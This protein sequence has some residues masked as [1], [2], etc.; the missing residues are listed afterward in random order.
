MRILQLAT[1]SQGGAGIAANRLH[2]ALVEVGI[3]STFYTLDKSAEA[4][5]EVAEFMLPRTRFRRYCSS[6]LTLFQRLLVQKDDK[7][8]TS[9]S[10]TE[11]KKLRKITKNFEVI[12][13]HATYNLV[14]ISKVNLL[15][16]RSQHLYLHLHDQR[17]FTGGCHYSSNC[18]KFK[19]DCG[20]CPQVRLI[21]RNLPK[22][23]LEQNQKT[24]QSLS[25]NLTV[26]SPSLW[27]AELAKESK[28]FSNIRVIQ[29]RNPIPSKYFRKSL[30]N[31]LNIITISFAASNLD[32]PYKGFKVFLK[33]LEMLPPTFFH[34]KNIHIVGKGPTP[35]FPNYVSY[36]HDE[37]LSDEEMINFYSSTSLLVVPSFEDNYP[38]VISEALAQGC[39]VIGANV[40]GISEMLRDFDM[41]LFEKGASTELGDL[42]RNFDFQDRRE[43][44]RDQASKIVSNE[45]VARIFLADYTE[46]F[47]GSSTLPN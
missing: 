27:L 9:L 23:E 10:L 34:G 37:S 38:N 8:I 35:I 28:V 12:H 6:F 30:T 16:N 42:L 14:D 22:R 33:A 4:S 25:K 39:E 2:K 26:V 43:Q 32:N 15:I 31:D 17:A 41:K 5:I 3:D 18:L 45:S 21:L 11:T 7:L 29:V 44:I 1:S 40:G 13:L 20:K 47:E 46:R 24:Y 19:T 36:V